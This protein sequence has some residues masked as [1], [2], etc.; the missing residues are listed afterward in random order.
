MKKLII[1]ALITGFLAVGA[2]ATT[3]PPPTTQPQ[4]VVLKIQSA[5]DAKVA[6]DESIN[7]TMVI[8]YDGLEFQSGGIVIGNTLYFPIWSYISGADTLSLW[9]NIQIAKHQG[10]K[11]LH[12]YINSGG[13]SGFD[14]LGISDVIQS[15]QK[16]GIKVIM[17]ANG[18]IASAA[19]PIFV[20][21]DH[22]IASQGTMFMIHQA[23]LFKFFSS[24]KQDDLIAQ[25]DMLRL[26]EDRYKCLV[27]SRSKL[28]I[29]DLTVKMARTTWFTATQ[30][31]EWGL[32]DE[33]K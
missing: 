31:K 13:G 2:C 6:I 33:I 17:E 1:I 30:A 29:D 25:S 19:V 8:P 18:L 3:I 16:D 28:S 11:T 10:I 22:R 32:V 26:L 15:A 21:G 23:Q 7:R 20:M 14:G 27:A 4:E 24:E 12:I 9:K 5:T